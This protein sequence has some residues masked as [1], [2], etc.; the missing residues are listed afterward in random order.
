MG[1]FGKIKQ[2]WN[3]GSLMAGLQAAGAIAQGDY[4]TAAQI[5]ALNRDQ[6]DERRQ[7]EAQAQQHEQLIAAAV[8]AGVPEE[9]ARSLPPQT[10]ASVV[11][12]YLGPQNDNE[13][14]R[15]LRAGGIDPASP[16]GQ[17]LYRQRAATM[18]S[19]APQMTGSPET[20][21][22]WNT[23]PPPQVPG[24]TSPPAQQTPA[25]QPAGNVINAEMYRG[26]TNGLGA[27]GAADWAQRNNIVVAVRSP[28]EARQLPSGT[29]I[30][31]PDGTIGRVP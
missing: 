6:R 1:I 3:D 11:G 20:G 16:E 12:Q 22:R 9:Q 10:L 7:S 8:R 18:A 26:A 28:Q 5:Q 27:Q 29:R 31:L 25:Q 19:P 17:N 14:T 21:Y 4:G 23:P 30:R 15:T 13:F 24:L 2:N